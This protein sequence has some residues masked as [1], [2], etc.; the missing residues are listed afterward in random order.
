MSSASS[1][2]SAFPSGPRA[3][4][5]AC[6]PSGQLSNGVTH[7]PKLSVL[8]DKLL[9][10]LLVC[11]S[12]IIAENLLLLKTLYKLVLP[13]ICS[14]QLNLRPFSSRPGFSTLLLKLKCLPCASILASMKRLLASDSSFLMAASCSVFALR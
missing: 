14:I 11:L 12:E 6:W 10:L 5:L 2:T 9:R 8:L 4:I 3:A 7:L 1:S 13:K